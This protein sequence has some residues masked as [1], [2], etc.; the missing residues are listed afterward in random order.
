M[1]LNTFLSQSGTIPL[2]IA[3]VPLCIIP[4]SGRVKMHFRKYGVAA[5]AFSSLIYV[6]E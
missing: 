1:S 3:P 4:Y 5:A 2:P 6:A